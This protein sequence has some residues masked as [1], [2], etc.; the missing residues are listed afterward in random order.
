MVCNGSETCKGV[1]LYCPVEG[2]TCNVKCIGTSSCAKMNY[3]I[4]SNDYNKLNT[5]QN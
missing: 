2:P 3:Y 5:K 1:D 4:P